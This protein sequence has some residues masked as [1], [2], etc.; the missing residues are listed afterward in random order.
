MTENFAQD[1]TEDAFGAAFGADFGAAFAVQDDLLGVCNDL[2]RL[3]GLLSGACTELSEGFRGACALIEQQRQQQRS[4]PGGAPDAFL[5]VLEQRLSSAVTALQFE[6]MAS[7]LVG[8]ARRV[9]RSSAE[10]LAADA[11]GDDD[12]A[13][14]P[15]DDAPRRP[16]PVTQDEM[17]AGSVE[18][19]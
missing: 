5:A 17:D 15:I 6:D 13:A 10:R 3:L 19:F 11:F 18:L 1:T 16:N 4:A 7:Q 2:E 12:D 14:A 9:L 8:H